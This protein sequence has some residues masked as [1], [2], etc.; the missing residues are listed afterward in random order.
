[1]DTV[2]LY[3]DDKEVVAKAGQTILD[4]ALAAGIY[5]PNICHHPSLKPV[6][7]CRLCVVEIEGQEGTH[8]SCNTIVREGM[9]V[10]TDSERLKKM[11]RVSLELLLT[12]HPD[13][14]STCPKYGKCVLQ[15]LIQYLGVSNARLLPRPYG[16]TPND[17]NPLFIHDMERC[18]KCGRCVRACRELR[19]VKVLDYQRD[20][21]GDVYIGCGKDLLADADC[22]FCGACVEVCPTGA[23]RDKRGVLKENVTREDALVPCRLA[24]PAHTDVPRYLRLIREGKYEDAVAVIREKAPLPLALGY[25]CTHPCEADCRRGLVNE[26]VS[27]RNLKRFAAEHD[28]GAWKARGFQKPDTGKKVAV[29]GAGP[30]GLTAAYYLRKLGHDVTVY[31]AMPEAGGMLRYG[32]P[33]Y[34]MPA[35]VLKKDVDNILSVGVKLVCNER[36][37]DIAALEKENDAVLVTVGAHL[38][39]RLPLEGND[40]PGVQLNIDY[41][42]KARLHEPTNT[43]ERV[44]VLGGGNVA[45]DCA[46]VA[47]R[48]GAKE[49][50]IA[51]LEARDKMT[52]SDDEILEGQEEGIQVHPAQSFL[53]IE[54][55]DKVEGVSLINVKSFSF[56]E[57]RRAV[58]ETE[59]GT[60]HTIPCDGV[61]FAV[62]QRPT[63]TEDMGLEFT[64]STH[65]KA[66]ENMATSREGVFA[67]GDVVT[68]T[69]SVIAAIASGRNAASGIDK[70]LGGDGCIDEKLVDTDEPD[71]FIGRV[72][73]F[74]YEKRVHPDMVGADARKCNFEAVESTFG[75]DAAH[76]ES[77]RCLQCDLRTKIEPPLFWS[78]VVKEGR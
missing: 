9:R 34:R 48:E 11:R 35:E 14:C 72:E 59:P 46:R 53:K 2:K 71:A 33:E 69:V 7:A 61:I 49:V 77:S 15:S 13:D 12:C 78:D 1:M 27:I 70:Y 60:E 31:E 10:R 68:G 41:L 28:Q 62:G 16:M 23:L 66:D 29:I 17:K 44:V 21:K 5:I 58:I 8:T 73:G 43:P 54:G 36:V 3:I 75:C 24:C 37:T 64:R 57:N 74:A 39:A 18:I 45:F 19:G 76:C 4:A 30:A 67:A 22:R 47:L 52:A 63:G 25:V 40:L 6:G 65:L 42:R 32:I 38:G 56:D 51:C 20:E 50:H 26:S 55:T